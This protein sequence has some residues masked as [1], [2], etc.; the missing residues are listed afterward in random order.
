M[1]ECFYFDNRLAD[2]HLLNEMMAEVYRQL[3]IFSR[4]KRAYEKEDIDRYFLNDRCNTIYSS[5]P[6]HIYRGF[7]KQYY[8]LL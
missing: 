7:A 3:L 4:P 1:F 6:E 2:K 5:Y 8:Q